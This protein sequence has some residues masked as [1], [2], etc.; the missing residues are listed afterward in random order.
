[1]LMIAALA[2]CGKSSDSSS[3]AENS[4]DTTS[5]ATDST[6]LETQEPTLA[7]EAG[8]VKNSSPAIDQLKKSGYN[9]SSL[10]ANVN[11][12][13][14][15]EIGFQLEKPK[16]GDT[17]A[18]LH[19]SMGDITIR[20]FPEYAPN[21]VNNFVELS[22]AGK[23]N[24]VLFHRVMNNFMIQTGDYENGNG[25]G[26][27][28][29][30][31]APFKDEFCDKLVNIRGSVAMANSGKDTNGS[32]FFINQCPAASYKENGVFKTYENNWEQIKAQLKS[33]KT[34]AQAVGSLANY[35]TSCLNT[36]AVPDAMKKLYNE[37]GGNI[38]L[39]GA[40]NPSDS[41]HTVFAQVI[42]G[43]DVVDKIAGA[44]VDENSKPT[45]DITINSV[46]ITE[47]K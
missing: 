47:Y 29:I 25:T 42:D 19:T 3:S 36:D 8:K 39:D 4:D 11:Y 32:Q 38:W 26:G 15:E 27:T 16:K 17:I 31:G 28:S 10:T 21:T 40:Y 46:D 20:F 18:V 7:A 41:G 6:P 2:S 22:K 37:N 1:M 23:Y 12:A 13:T 14:K 35:G 33:N 9:T 5:A 44:S 24:G 30:Y 34:D 43:M 45:K